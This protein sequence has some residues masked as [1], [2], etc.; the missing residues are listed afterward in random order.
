M[1][2]FVNKWWKL[3]A[4]ALTLGVGIFLRTTNLME[5]PPA[6]YWE[7]VALGYDAYSI[8]LTGKDHHGNRWPL[9]AFE[10]F[11]D[12]KPSLYFYS[13]VPFIASLG[14]EAWVVRL[15]SVLAGIL[16]MVVVGLLTK[17]V[18][19]RL[20]LAN[21]D[22]Y[23]LVGLLVAGISPWAVHFSRGGWEVNLAT[24]LLS[25][26]VFVGLQVVKT[27]QAKNVPRVSFTIWR[28]MLTVL[29]LVLSVYAYHGTR[30]IAPLVGVMVA[31]SWLYEL[32]QDKQ[33]LTALFKQLSIPALLGLVLMAPILIALSSPQVTQRFAET[34][35]FSQ[36]DVIIES[37]EAKNKAGNSFLSSLFYHRYLLFGR[38]II[39]NYFDHFSVSFLIGNGDPNPRHG[40]QFGGHLYYQDILFLIVGIGL[41][42]SRRKTISG[43]VLGWWLLGI[44]PAALTTATPHALRTLPSMPAVLI[45]ISLG[46]GSTFRWLSESFKTIAK[47]QT[48]QLGIKPFLSVCIAGSYVLAFVWWWRHYQTI[49]RVQASSE[50]QYGYQQMVESVNQLRQKYPDLPVYITREQ[51]RPAMYYWFFSKTDPRQVQAANATASK[52]QGEFTSFENIRFPNTVAEITTTPAIVASSLDNKDS[53]VV[54]GHTVVDE[55]VIKDLNG[56]PSWIIYVVLL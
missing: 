44:V 18:A 20:S 28:A 35:I 52:D 9:V 39:T 15:P 37:N 12:W 50:W 32:K 22:A 30:V 51:G 43:L 3:I 11:G 13:L 26:G 17:L 49:Y 56:Q 40:S 55:T 7:E 1:L 2:D 42:F 36:L 25:W 23:G 34:S 6:L 46:I 41:L 29:V 21:A 54:E 38:E 8:A 19:Q 48:L 47:N 4:V 5:S 14:L 53:L 33:S 45:I 16:T 10:S 24:A 27:N 31:L